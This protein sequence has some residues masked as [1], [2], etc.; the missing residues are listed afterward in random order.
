MGVLSQT[1]SDTVTVAVRAECTCILLLLLLLF[2]KCV[3]L[4]SLFAQ[5]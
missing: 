3:Y 2:M 5:V 4:F 1:W